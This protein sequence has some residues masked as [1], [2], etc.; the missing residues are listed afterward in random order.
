MDDG[1]LTSGQLTSG[2]R[3]VA[4]HP[5]I[6]VVAKPGLART[7][8]H[9]GSSAPRLSNAKVAA[10]KET[11]ARCRRIIPGLPS[12]SQQELGKLHYVTVA[13][14][15]GASDEALRAVKGIGPGK[16]KAIREFC[17]KYTGDTEAERAVDLVF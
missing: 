1:S 8:L 3:I 12:G 13:A 15:R 4:H 11:V 9:D 14:L 2:G 10:M 7:D 17:A 6:F 16:L 5:C